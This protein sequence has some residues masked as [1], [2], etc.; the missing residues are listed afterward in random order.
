[1][2]AHWQVMELY[3]QMGRM[4]VFREARAILDVGSCDVSCEE[5]A[6]PVA[7]F[8]ENVGKPHTL[9]AEDAPR[10]A[11]GPARR[12]FEALG[13]HYD[14][15]DI[16]RR[17]GT[18]PLDLN[19]DSTPIAMKNFYDIVLNNGTT[20]HILNQFNCFKFIHEVTAPGGY[21]FHHLPFIGHFNHGLFNYQP[22]FFVELAKSNR[23]SLEGLWISNDGPGYEPFENNAPPET[24]H[25]II[26]VLQRKLLNSPFR[27][28]YNW[29]GSDTMAGEEFVPLHARTTN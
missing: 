1:M 25:A 28:P 26:F 7:R 16:D 22:D 21:I 2:G 9:S 15:V 5:N 3:A 13:Y 4:G 11:N 24:S 29:N 20:E 17:P 18:I 8:L 14:C 23:Y 12:L 6:D 27:A 10:Y 19:Y